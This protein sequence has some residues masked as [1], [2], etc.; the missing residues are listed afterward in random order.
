MPVS[1]KVVV[2]GNNIKITFRDTY[3]N[4]VGGFQGRVS[5]FTPGRTFVADDST[6]YWKVIKPEALGVLKV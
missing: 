3:N 1:C 4:P 6:C 5:D 2:E